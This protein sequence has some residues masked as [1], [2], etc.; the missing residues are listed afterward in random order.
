MAYT[1]DAVLSKLS[2]LNETHESIA[3]TAQWIMFH[4]RHASQTVHLW[5]NKLKDLPSSKRLNMI[6]LANGLYFDCVTA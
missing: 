2:A 3:T 5:L 6:Y 1:D 4:R